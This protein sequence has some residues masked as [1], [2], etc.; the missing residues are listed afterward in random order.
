MVAELNALVPKLE[1]IE[2][3]SATLKTA[4][5]GS[6]ELSPL[7]YG[8]NNQLLHNVSEI[9]ANSPYFDEI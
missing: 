1:L 4:G 5:G 8:D 7:Y 9:A 2:D 3:P 6:D